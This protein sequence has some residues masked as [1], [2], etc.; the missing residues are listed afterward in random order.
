[1]SRT[2]VLFI[3][4]SFVRR[5]ESSKIDIGIDLS[6]SYI[7]YC[8]FVD[9]KPLNFI[10]QLV[11]FLPNFRKMYLIPDVVVLMLGTNDLGS[12][13]Q[14]SPMGLALRLAAVGK[15]FVKKGAKRVIFTE[16]IPR[17]GDSAFR[18]CPQFLQR[19]DGT[20]MT[21]TEA[22]EKFLA[23]ADEFNLIIAF[24]CKANGE[25]TALR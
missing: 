14:E 19:V 13:P 11:Q 21:T 4:H 5:L 12:F 2:H 15:W 17:L 16:V 10:E 20:T 24:Y 1:M 7:E 6:R 25:C 3:G 22:E 18:P 23:R 8:G 9:S